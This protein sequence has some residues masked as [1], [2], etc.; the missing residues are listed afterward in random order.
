MVTS[1][2][3]I[4]VEMPDPFLGLSFLAHLRID[5]TSQ[6][7]GQDWPRVGDEVIGAVELVIGSDPPVGSGVYRIVRPPAN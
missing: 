7:R 5:S 1:H 6:H 4:P 2:V 3:D